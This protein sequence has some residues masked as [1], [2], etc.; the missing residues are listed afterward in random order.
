MKPGAKSLQ[1]RQWAILR[2][3]LYALLIGLCLSGIYFAFTGENGVAKF[4]ILIFGM[5][6][7]LTV[8]K[9][10]LAA[11]EGNPEGAA[12][13]FLNYS[14][15][16]RRFCAFFIDCLL[17]GALERC[18]RVFL[19]LSQWADSY[20]P[21]PEAYVWTPILLPL[22]YF[23]VFEASPLQG[24]LGKRLL[25]FH[26]AGRGGARLPWWR[27]LLRNVLRPVSIIPL[28]MGYFAIWFT[29]RRQALHD[30]M[31]GSIH[32]IGAPQSKNPAERFPQ[33]PET[34]ALV[35]PHA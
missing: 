22:F 14:G 19:G 4:A 35:S 31:T 24:T 23:A 2:P 33:P 5:P 9:L 34:G 30:L 20:E 26:V 21:W 12:Q 13:P 3:G 32:V 18:V 15:L 8:R 16:D 28:G 7:I 11:R 29:P 1:S 25:R 10:V 27:A 17:V 6:V